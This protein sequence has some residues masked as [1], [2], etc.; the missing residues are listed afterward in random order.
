MLKLRLITAAILLPLLV[1]SILWLPDLYFALFVAVFACVGSWE[2][3]RFLCASKSAQL[4]VFRWLYVI[5]VAALLLAS[6]MFVIGNAQLTGLVLNIAIAWWLLAIV[7]II[8][9]PGGEWFR[10]NLIFKSMAGILVLLP[11]WVAQV[12]LRNDHVAGIE[13]L[14]YLLVLIVAADT[15]AYFGGRKFGKHKLAPKVSPGKTW[16]GVAA[17]MFCVSVV[18]LVYCYSLE[19][20]H[21]GWNNVLVFIGLSLV[22]AMFS[23]V[24]D[25]TESLYKREAGLKDS[26]T[27][28][29]GHGGVLDRI[30]SLTAAAP[31]FL[32]C[33]GW[34]YF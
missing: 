33:L 20:H 12:S 34:F 8:V 14:L 17:G 11:S 19:L 23:V 6:W 16:E 2:W 28:L 27:I 22:T 32:A 7:L 10:K 4:T 24:G 25:L 29:P 5:L 9:F 31:V 1:G 30:D 3:T 21:Q 18:S 26:G 15:G 13:L